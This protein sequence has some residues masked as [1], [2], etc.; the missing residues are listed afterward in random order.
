M[1]HVD[2]TSQSEKNS[3]LIVYVVQEQCH[4]ATAVSRPMNV[5]TR[6]HLHTP[7]TGI[8]IIVIIIIIF[9]YL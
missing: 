8:I 9:V 7:D 5:I 4:N 3:E 1:R 2:G 6:R